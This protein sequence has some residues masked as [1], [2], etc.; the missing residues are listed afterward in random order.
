MPSYQEV[1]IQGRLPVK[2]YLPLLANAIALT[3]MLTT[4]SNTGVGRQEAC[5]RA[6]AVYYTAP[7]PE[8]TARQN[9]IFFK[10]KPLEK[11]LR[12]ATVHNDYY[13]KTKKEKK[14]SRRDSYQLLLS[15]QGFRHVEASAT[16]QRARP[17]AARS[18]H[19]ARDRLLSPA[20]ISPS[21]NRWRFINWITW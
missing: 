2:W 20:H 18:R 21:S 3:H 4:V 13:K 8:I 11:K 15:C 17:L 7:F 9:L 14:K 1:S 10:K 19:A 12:V 6:G 5:E 16:S